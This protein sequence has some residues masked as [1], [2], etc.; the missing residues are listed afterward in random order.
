MVGRNTLWGNLTT[1]SDILTPRRGF[2]STWKLGEPGSP[3]E[4]TGP[5]K[6]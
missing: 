3:G 6:A 1:G 4:G 2:G 5:T